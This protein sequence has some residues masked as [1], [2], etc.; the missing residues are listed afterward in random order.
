LRL[1]NAWLPKDDDA[2]GESLRYYFWFQTLA[3]WGLTTI[4]VAGFTG[5]V[6]NN[7]K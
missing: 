7:N 1:K 6:R 2:D 3:G 4:W 5:L